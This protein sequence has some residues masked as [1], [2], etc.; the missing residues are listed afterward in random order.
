MTP[1]LVLLFGMHP[2]TAVGT[3]LLYAAVTKA[4]GTIVH[5][6]R[7]HVR[8]ESSAGSRPAA[9]PARC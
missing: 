6:R 7:G 8:W 2:A 3:D 9:F 5:A 4:G 1:L